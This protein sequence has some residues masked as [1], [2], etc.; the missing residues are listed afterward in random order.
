MILSS[1]GKYHVQRSM[2][3]NVPNLVDAM[4]DNPGLEE[5]LR[6]QS[7][8][9]TND[10][11]KAIFENTVNKQ[12]ESVMNQMND[13]NTLKKQEQEFM[14]SQQI[15]QKQLD[16]Q[17]KQMAHQQML[18]RQTLDKVKQLEE[19]QKQLNMQR[20]DSRSM[21]TETSHAKSRDQ[22]DQQQKTMRQPFMPK[23][24]QNKFVT[25]TQQPLSVTTNKK[26]PIITEY[27]N[28][29]NMRMGLGA[30]MP[31]DN[32]I[33]DLVTIDDD[34]D[35]IISRGFETSSHTESQSKESI[36]KRK[37]GR[38]KKMPNNNRSSI[39]INT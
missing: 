13:L 25:P 29:Q 32:R 6:K 23:S 4:K 21:Y 1:A 7:Q 27:N 35:N 8:R 19:L 26:Q 17:E 10:K 14:K 9:D 37:V 11:Q 30:V 38:P 15:F 16:Q 5:K 24:L 12:H 2:I 18:Q 31:P 36:R 28:A 3:P 34:V 20:S 39:Q 33:N 22:H